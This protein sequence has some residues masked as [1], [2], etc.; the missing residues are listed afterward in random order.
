MICESL[1]FPFAVVGLLSGLHIASLEA[2]TKFRPKRFMT[3]IVISF[4][5]AL[6]L[7]I[8]I[9]DI[10]PGI[11]FAMLIGIE[12]IRFALYKDIKKIWAVLILGA[13][14]VIT[15][16][17]PIEPSLLNGLIWGVFAGV[18]GTYI[19][20]TTYRLVPIGGI[21]GAI[22][23]VFTFDYGFL[24]LGVM[25]AERIVVGL[26]KLKKG[27]KAFLIPYIFT[28]LIFLFLFTRCT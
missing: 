5:A 7:S 9:Y 10:N 13:F 22:F 23:S 2:Y 3:S 21:I 8:Y 4:L 25:G 15:T 19:F 14:V 11:L 18:I 26:L 24:L 17:M 6:Y 27:K 16:V 28:W 1:A 12:R 20:G